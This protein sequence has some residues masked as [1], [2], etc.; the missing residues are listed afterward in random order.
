MNNFNETI[1]KIMVEK[2]ISYKEA[3]KFIPIEELPE[4]VVAEDVN[5]DEPVEQ[6]DTEIKPGN[7]KTEY[8]DNDWRKVIYSRKWEF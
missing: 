6:I 3:L 4:N 7:F 1:T 2:G 8:A 5:W